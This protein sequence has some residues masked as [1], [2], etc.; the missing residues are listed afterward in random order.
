[1]ESVGIRC[2]CC[3]LDSKI[4]SAL[5][6]T[7]VSNDHS[8]LLTRIDFKIIEISGSSIVLF[9]Y[10]GQADSKTGTRYIRIETLNTTIL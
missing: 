7:V 2:T 4:L 8:Q 1:M 6:L 10:D 9:V 3:H 5:Y